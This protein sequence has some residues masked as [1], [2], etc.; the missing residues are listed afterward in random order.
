M[1]RVQK[2]LNRD[3]EQIWRQTVYGLTPDSPGQRW[4]GERLDENAATAVSSSRSQMDVAS[5][6]TCRIISQQLS[7][8]V[9]VCVCDRR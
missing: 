9:R 1:S 2:R 3:D 5:S 6:V 4:R 8:C 7:A